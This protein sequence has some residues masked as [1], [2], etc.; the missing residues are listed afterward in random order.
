MRPGFLRR[1][2]VVVTVGEA[3]GFAV[4]AVVGATLYDESAAIL[5]PALL[6]AGAV[7]GGLLGGAQWLALRAELPALAPATWVGLTAAGAVTAYAIGVLPSTFW[8][9]WSGWAP[10]LQVPLFVVLGLALLASIGAAQWLELRHHVPQAGRWI[11]GTALAWT[12][13]LGVF[14]A[15]STPLWQEGQELWLRIAIG[16]LAGLAMAVTMAAVTGR[17]MIGLLHR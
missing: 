9:T 12:L 15:I 13:A 11:L 17:A 14:V 10:A 3:L 6:A 2:I 8:E 7:E 5:V 4:P 16:L 1:W